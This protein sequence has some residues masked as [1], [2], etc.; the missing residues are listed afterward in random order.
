MN[1]LPDA[2]DLKMSL[3]SRALDVELVD[4]TDRRLFAGFAKLRGKVWTI[5]WSAYNT[6]RKGPWT[7]MVHEQG[8]EERQFTTR[9]GVMRYFMDKIT[10]LGKEGI[11]RG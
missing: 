1:I 11:W 3:S 8:G 6:A 2:F 5:T 10:A 9:R 7:E 4:M